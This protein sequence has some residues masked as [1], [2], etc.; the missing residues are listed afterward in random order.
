MFQPNER[1][2]LLLRAALAAGLSLLF[3]VVYGGCNWI[4]AQR[5]HVPSYFWEWERSLPFVPALILPYLSIDLFFVA[6]PFVCQRRTELLTFGKRVVAAILAAGL[7]FLLFPLRFG[8]SRPKASGWPG[9]IFDWF[10]ALDAPYNLLPSLHAAFLVLLWKVYAR[11]LQ[12]AV[13]VL[14]LVWFVLIGLSPVLTYQHHVIDILGGFALGAVCLVYF[15][16]NRA[17]NELLTRLP[18]RSA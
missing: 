6:A 12:G 4:T 3:L 15:R 5:A 7:C 1:V 17:P 2:S 11:S 18:R 16:E 8:F 13:R 9:A 10:R 14:V